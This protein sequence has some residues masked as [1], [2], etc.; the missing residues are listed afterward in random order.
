MV[1]SPLFVLNTAREAAICVSGARHQKR[2]S[3][4]SRPPESAN[5]LAL[6]S[7]ANRENGG[8]D[9]SATQGKR[10]ISWDMR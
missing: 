6:R 9:F 7:R 1:P 3:L 8:G 10:R 4:P 2:S 5:G